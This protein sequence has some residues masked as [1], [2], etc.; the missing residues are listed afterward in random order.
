MRDLIDH[1][2]LREKEGIT[3]AGLVELMVNA[4]VDVKPGFIKWDAAM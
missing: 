2:E 3:Y 1:Y 4:M